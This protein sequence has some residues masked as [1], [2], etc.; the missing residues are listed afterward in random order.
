M[1]SCHEDPRQ[2][3]FAHAEVVWEDDVVRVYCA[4]P[5]AA[6]AD[7]AATAATGGAIAISNAGLAG[8]TPATGTG[9]TLGGSPLQ[10]GLRAGGEV[11]GA[12]AY[13]SRPVPP[14]SRAG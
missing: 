1:L 10:V 12:A 3:G 13:A 6:P 7:P 14:L 11:R 4:L 8:A 5:H 9:A 2:S